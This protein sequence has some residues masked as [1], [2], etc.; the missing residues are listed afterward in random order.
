MVPEGPRA[1]NERSAAGPPLRTDLALRGRAGE[2]TQ[3]MLAGAPAPVVPSATMND[4]HFL[5]GLVR[6][7]MFG[8]LAW[9]AVGGSDP[10]AAGV[11]WNREGALR[12]LL[13]LRVREEFLPNAYTF[14]PEGSDDRHW[15]RVRT[16]LGLQWQPRQEHAFEIRL[17]NELRDT[18]G[19]A[20]VD[21]DWDEI[22]LD[23][24]LW[25]WRGEGTVPFTLT[26]GRQDIIWNDGFLFF[27]GHPL[28]GSRTMYQNG[29][30]LQLEGTESVVEI[31]GIANPKRDR[32]VVAGDEQR[33]LQDAD[34]RAVALRLAHEDGR[35]L[36]FVWKDEEDPD[37]LHPDVTSLTLSLRLHTE[38]GDYPGVLGQ[39]AFQ[40]Q[41]TEDDDGF[42]LAGQTWLQRT[43]ESGVRVRLGGLY[44][45]GH[46][47]GE[48][49]GGLRG[50]RSLYGRWPK[51]SEL[52][53][54]TLIGESGVGNWQNIAAPC[55]EVSSPVFSRFDLRLTTYLLFAPE[56]TWEGRGRLFQARL[57]HEVVKGIR[58]HLLWE[59]LTSGSY[60]TPQLEDAHFLRWELNYE[61]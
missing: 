13:S 50:F 16:R 60:P 37:G 46:P 3:R 10:A 61:L 15:L 51:W 54:Y 35:E 18:Y 57:G 59:W 19:P 25:R 45:S 28:D 27:E 7:A 38:E 24:I 53:L 36:A 43:S 4:S 41:A 9:A 34:E 52:Y 58:G 31:I 29:V 11:V 44:Y 49:E 21:F 17:I 42:A 23:R 30:R 1:I 14:V 55:L 6:F 26:V 40:H 33:D 8:M 56:P 20:S 22:V 12:P 48:E 39:I 2:A 47:E 32:W 5:R